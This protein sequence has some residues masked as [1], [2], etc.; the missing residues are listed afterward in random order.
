MDII[1]R[2][3][4]PCDLDTIKQIIFDA[5]SHYVP[6]IGTTPGPMRDDYA[7]MIASRKLYV[8]E[9]AQ[10]TIQGLV[11]VSPR[12]DCMVLSNL[13]VAPSA[14]GAGLG[15]KLLHFAEGLAVDCGYK[16]M[17]LYTNELMTENIQIYGKKGYVETHRGEERGLKRVYMSKT[18]DTKPGR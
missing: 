3:G 4:T 5:Y 15:R 18:L 12:D 8:A 6:R 13:A 14:Q 16:V 17:K 2:L 11:V 1:I 7:P 10:G 9:D